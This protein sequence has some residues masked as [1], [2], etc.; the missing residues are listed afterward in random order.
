MVTGHQG[1]GVMIND[2]QVC[3]CMSKYAGGGRG[4]G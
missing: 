4:G 3:V 2:V 1:V